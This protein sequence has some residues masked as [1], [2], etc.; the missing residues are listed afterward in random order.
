MAKSP[1]VRLSD[2]QR[3]RIERAH[4]RGGDYTICDQSWAG[5][6]DERHSVHGMVRAGLM[7]RVGQ[8]SDDPTATVFRLTDAARRAYA[9]DGRIVR[10]HRCD[11]PVCCGTWPTDDGQ[12]IRTHGSCPVCSRWIALTKTGAMRRHSDWDGGPACAGTGRIAEHLA[13]VG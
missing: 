6:V 5:Q 4:L 11:N 10:N 13:E 3:V 1:A 8:S 7:E 12:V 9:T 2:A